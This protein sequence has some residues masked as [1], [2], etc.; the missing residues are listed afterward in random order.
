M[1]IK[2]IKGWHGL[3]LDSLQCLEPYLEKRFGLEFT[4]II[5]HDPGNTGVQLFP[6]NTAATPHRRV[7]PRFFNL[8]L[9]AGHLGFADFLGIGGGA[10][11]RPPRGRAG[12][13]WL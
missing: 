4:D 3:L 9:V 1:G 13:T 12:A 6:F 10:L 11:S 7:N 2:G 8:D 5:L